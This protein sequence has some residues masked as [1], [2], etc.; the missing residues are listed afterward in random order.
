MAEH[1]K[2][3]FYATDKPLRLRN[4]TC[5]YCRI[6][7]GPGQKRTKEHVIGRDFVPEVDFNHQWNL[8]VNACEACNN[9]KSD[10]EGELGA[11]SMQPDV[12]GR[13]AHDDERLA[14]QAKRKGCGAVSARTGKPIAESQER[15]TVKGQLME[16]AT[17]T[18]GF[19]GPPQPSRGRVVRLAEMHLLAFC[20]LVSYDRQTQQG[21]GPTGVILPLSIAFKGDWG[22]A[23]LR[24]FQD[25]VTEWPFRVHA[26]AA[27]GYFKLFIR[28]KEGSEL[29]GWALEWNRNLRL[30]GFLGEEAAVREVVA[31]LPP[32]R[33][34][35]GYREDVPLPEDEDRL[36]DGPVRT[37]SGESS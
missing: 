21:G 22:N 4:S 31:S 17:V 14:R 37:E 8:I 20:Y 25:Q 10:L 1:G 24:S 33:D 13:F 7:L 16:G 35:R 6:K 2:L 11:L 12:F 19:V 29:W 18:F 5:V 23:V 36:F 34:K 3:Q 15:L 27:D 30:A 32:L 26:L 9:E 28:R